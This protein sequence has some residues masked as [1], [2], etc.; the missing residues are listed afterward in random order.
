MSSAPPSSTVPQSV[1]LLSPAV[2][3]GNVGD[4]FIELAIRRLLNP[5]TRFERFSVRRSLDDSDIDRINA[6]DC[7][8]I[9]GT[10]LY[11]RDWHS[12]LRIRDL[13]R[14]KVPVIPFGVGTSAHSLAEHEVSA[15]TAVM[16]R[17]IHDHCEVGGVRDEHSAEVVTGL[18]VRNVVVTGCPVLFWAGAGCLPA[19]RPTRREKIVITARNWLMHRWPD[20]IDHPVQIEFLAG[21]LEQLTGVE[22][23]FAIH[24]E[25]DRRLIDLLDLEQ[26]TVVDVDDPVP[27]IDLYTDPEVVVLAMRLHAGMLAVANGTP[28]VF[29]GHDSRTYAFCD[30]LGFS[31][32]ELFSPDAVSAAV[33]GLRRAL[34]GKPD[35]P[36]AAAAQF[37]VLS[38]AMSD[39]LTSN[40]LT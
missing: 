11:Q 38:Q 36:G 24:E 14:I 9:C 22:L 26:A 6:A 3:T 32:V 13:D 17:A 15:E 21:V 10:N 5:D 18:G 4:H 29:V 2:G 1:A 40:E 28:A 30:L 25:Y 35:F 33:G 19:P 27:Y 12:E 7:A 23:V 39:F 34:D 31:W 8:L 16:I 37:A 20:N